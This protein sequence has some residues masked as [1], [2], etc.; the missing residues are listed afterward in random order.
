MLRSPTHDRVV[1]E[2]RAMAARGRTAELEAA[3][4]GE[5]QEFSD[6]II[7]KVLREDWI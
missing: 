1:P 6:L 2:L 3:Y 7:R 5:G 4:A